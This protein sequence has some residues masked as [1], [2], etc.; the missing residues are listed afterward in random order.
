MSSVS[1]LNRVLATSSS[2]STLPE[3][4][5]SASN[6]AKE[7][8]KEKKEEFVVVEAEKQFSIDD[9]LL[10]YVQRALMVRRPRGSG[11]SRNAVFPMEMNTVKVYVASAGQVV[12]GAARYGLTSDY[13]GFSTMSAVFARFR[14][15]HVSVFVTQG[16][17]DS[18]SSGTPHN[19]VV[20]MNPADTTGT[21][22][23]L[24]T[25]WEIPGSVLVNTSTLPSGAIG[26][27]KPVLRSKVL[28]EQDW[29]QTVSDSQKGCFPFYGTGWTAST[30]DLNF[31]IRSRF[32]F[33]GILI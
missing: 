27:I 4:K 12:A 24:A 20:A 15:V 7:E 28:P 31:W 1:I 9:H 11:L 25:C 2:K 21:P 33:S 17:A 6:Q 10:S 32:E 13:A 8:K 16:L 18:S 26:R 3:T 5:T 23:N 29:F 30:G 22:S 19:L 14:I